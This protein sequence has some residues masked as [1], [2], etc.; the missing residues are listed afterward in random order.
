MH[1]MGMWTVI[2]MI[3]RKDGP[4]KVELYSYYNYDTRQTMLS[5]VRKL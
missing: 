4:L 5:V 2:D 3:K 1:M